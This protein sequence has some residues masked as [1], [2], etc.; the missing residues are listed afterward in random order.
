M[1]AYHS[2][3]GIPAV[4]HKQLLSDILRGEWGFKYYVSRESAMIRDYDQRT[5]FNH[6]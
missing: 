5:E 1:S 4:A 2:Y 6:V 3:D